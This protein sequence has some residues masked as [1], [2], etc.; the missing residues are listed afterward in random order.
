MQASLSGIEPMIVAI[1]CALLWYFCEYE[2]RS[3]WREYA[4]ISPVLIRLGTAVANFRTATVLKFHY[5]ML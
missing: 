1:C 2:A 4:L 3:V 5:Y